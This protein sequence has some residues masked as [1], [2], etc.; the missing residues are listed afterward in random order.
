MLVKEEETCRRIRNAQ[1]DIMTTA[2]SCRRRPSRTPALCSRLPPVSLLTE[3]DAFFT[4]H[5]QC[6][7]WTLAS[8]A[9]PVVWIDYECGARIAR[10]VTNRAEGHRG[11]RVR[12]VVH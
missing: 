5:R 9:R 1:T 8:T 2:G 10:K 11:R 4:D 7:I 12:A 3:L 6:A